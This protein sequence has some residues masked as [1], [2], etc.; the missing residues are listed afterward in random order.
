[1][2][3]QGRA[4]VLVVVL[5]LAVALVCAAAVAPPAQAGCTISG[6]VYD[7]ATGHP[8]VGSPIIVEV[9]RW[10]PVE[11]EWFG[12]GSAQVERD[13]QMGAGT[14]VL[15]DLAPHTWYV[16]MIDPI[17]GLWAS[18]YWSGKLTR[19]AADPVTLADG[20][21]AVCDFQATPGGK[22]A[23]RVT[24]ASGEPFSRVDV[25]AR[26]WTG[27]TIDSGTMGW[28]VSGSDGTY[29][30]DGLAAGEYCVIF[31]DQGV[32]GQQFWNDVDVM[33]LCTPVSVTPGGTAT[34]IDARIRPP[35]APVFAAKTTYT[36]SL[37]VVKGKAQAGAK[38]RVAVDGR[39][40]AAT[41]VDETGDWAVK[42]AGGYAQ[43]S[44][45]ATARATNGLGAG[46]AGKGKIV[47]DRTRPVVSAPRAASCAA[48]GTVLL[49]YSVRDKLSPAAKVTIRLTTK[50]GRVVLTRKL[51]VVP[52]G[53]GDDSF[54][55]TLAPGSYRFT[56]SAA[57]LA[58]N[59]AKA[60]S[61]TLTVN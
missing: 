27:S 6:T 36:R 26:L 42:A 32:Y 21:S 39:A 19:T 37:R 41:T 5:T 11:K 60:A 56:V 51:G 59:R 47:V 8:V 54:G 43:G 33:S 44:H 35:R 30:I 38:L 10:D 2:T 23:G 49:R 16:Q 24:D 53:A 45:T 22:I 14:Y 55:C 17:G 13:I 4:L 20:E 58:G 7:A 18:Q 34:G 3:M 15:R 40:L 1:M 28:G 46:P 57:D 31:G 52:T 9:S 12:G 25:E 50:A 61:N 48:G 29:V